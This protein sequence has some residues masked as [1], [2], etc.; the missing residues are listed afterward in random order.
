MSST[1]CVSVITVFM[2][3]F[4]NMGY[5]KKLVADNGPPFCAEDFVAFLT[6]V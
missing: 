1:D 4:A 5:P 3:I 2:P 6:K